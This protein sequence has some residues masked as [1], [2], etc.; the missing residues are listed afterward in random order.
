MQT[1]VIS[2][3]ILWLLVIVL[4]AIVAA[5]ARQVGLLHERIA[6]AGAL[7][8]AKGPRVGAPLPALSLQT[9]TGLPIDLT[10]NDPGGKS[11]LLFF[12]SP[13][14][15]VCK[16]LLPVLKSSQ[17]AESDWVRFIL[18]S[19]GEIKEQ[20]DFVSRAKLENFDYVVSS[21][22]GRELQIGKLPYVVLA[23]E[24]GE[25]R[26]HGLVNSRE[27]I[28]S[29]FKAKELGVASIQDYL[30]QQGVETA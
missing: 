17:K 29:I 28:E 24:Q 27:H 25:I 12:L 7:A 20:T 26:A 1:L 23:D 30:V 2:N 8:M 3:V 18:A 22:L 9:L 11:R 10:A 4:C 14:C 21:E 15:P 6:P 13:T 19:D 16:T 5:L